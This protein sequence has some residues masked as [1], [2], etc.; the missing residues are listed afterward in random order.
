MAGAIARWLQMRGESPGFT[1]S[2]ELLGQT[3]F[4]R[5]LSVGVHS[6]DCAAGAPCG[7]RLGAA[8]PIQG[9]LSDG[10]R[11]SLEWLV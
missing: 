4:P 5:Q 10:E 7:A 9:A 3:A 1:P 2:G 6:V 8:L 11:G